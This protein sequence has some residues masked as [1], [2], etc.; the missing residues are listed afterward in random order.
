MA[1]YRVYGTVRIGVSI[2]VE[3]DSDADALDIAH[4]SFIGLTNYAG[5]GGTDQLVGVYDRDVSL[6]A[7]GYEAEFTEAEETP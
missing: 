3:A 4:E 2:N 6:D 1:K 5:N 7:E